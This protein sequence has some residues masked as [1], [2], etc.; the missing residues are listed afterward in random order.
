[1]GIFP[2]WDNYTKLGNKTFVPN[3]AN[4]NDQ[5]VIYLHDA[6][7]ESRSLLAIGSLRSIGFKNPS[8]SSLENLQ[9]FLTAKKTW[10]FGWI[11]YDVK[12]AIEALETDK[13]DF[14]ELPDLFFCEP[15]IVIEINRGDLKVLK[16]KDEPDLESIQKS[17]LEN[18]E[19]NPLHLGELTPRTPKEAYIKAIEILLKHIQRGDIYEINY[20][21]DFYSEHHPIHPFNTYQKLHSLTKAPFSVYLKHKQNYLLCASPERYL[22]KK[23]N[24]LTSEPIKGT[25][26]R[27]KTTE[28]DELL[29]TELKND[30]KERG[31]N[32]MITDLVRNDLSKVARKGTV[33][34]EELCAIHSF[35]TVHQMISKVSAEV[36]SD[37]NFVDILR[38]T[39]PM[40]SM[41]GAPKVRAMQLTDRYEAARRGLYSGSVGYITPEGDFDFNVVIRSL[42]YNAHSHYL[43][44]K[45]GGAI[46]ALSS[47]EK[48][49][50]ECLLKADALFRSLR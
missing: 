32:I 35:E 28:E 39:F 22:S 11:G 17:L 9:T 24:T 34:V 45:V 38:A 14:F 33:K 50:E 15:R 30:I 27:G 43:S 8:K 23:G 26:K 3:L 13:P 19:K 12:N 42:L 10:L 46:T 44:A 6:L 47:P 36:A 7:K 18:P 40:G 20:C 29:K 16:G 31:E 4:L 2:K 49:Y 48:E 21:Q 37:I 5:T 1:M 25:T 41:T